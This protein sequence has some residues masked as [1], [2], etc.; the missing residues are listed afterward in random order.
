MASL[1]DVLFWREMKSIKSTVFSKCWKHMKM[2]SESKWLLQLLRTNMSSFTSER[3]VNESQNT[4]QESKLLVIDLIRSLILFHNSSYFF[5]VSLLSSVGISVR[6]LFPLHFS[7]HL[8]LAFAFNAKTFTI[9]IIFFSFSFSIVFLEGL[10][11]VIFRFFM[12]PGS[13]ILIW[14][15][16]CF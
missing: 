13:E 1:K 7:M 5:S 11:K 9:T 6:Y 2:N 8:F 14:Y 12:W 10:A 4:I 15:A 3:T 16:V